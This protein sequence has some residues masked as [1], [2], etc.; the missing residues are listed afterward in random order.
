[1][2][3]DVTI[4]IALRGTDM[5]PGR[6]RSKEIAEIIELIEDAIA[7]MVISSHP[8]LKK[9]DIRIGLKQINEGS[10]DLEFV[11]N[12]PALTLPATKKIT[13]AI[14]SND[15]SNLPLAS[16]S[17]LKSISAFTRRHKCVAE[18]AT[19]NGVR[20]SLAV[21]TPETIIPDAYP[22]SGETMLYG[23]IMR[24]GGATPKI[25][26]RTLSG[27]IIYCSATKDIVK[28]AGSKLYME[29]GLNGMAEWNSETYAIEA[30]HVTEIS[31]YQHLPLKNA[32]EAF[33]DIVQDSF[34]SIEDVNQLVRETRYGNPEV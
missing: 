28:R 7:S 20:E 22:L 5:R 23:E 16:V 32:F 33:R 3:H 30:F 10:I 29:V 18:W 6:I 14:T 13:Q 9:E 1:M 31:E 27:Q 4:N 25:Q 15:F 19:T 11:P 26:F 17:S 2:A 34:D 24:V 21:L 12:L 8:D